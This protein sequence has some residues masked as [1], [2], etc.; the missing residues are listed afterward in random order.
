M[1]EKEVEFPKEI[2]AIS[3]RNGQFYN[4]Q[5]CPDLKCESCGK[6]GSYDVDSNGVGLCA[7]C[8]RMTYDV[9]LEGNADVLWEK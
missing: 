3:F 4:E 7:K 2:I 8:L 5:F 6:T 1:E 9:I